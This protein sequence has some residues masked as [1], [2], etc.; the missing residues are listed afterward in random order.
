MKN[1]SYLITETFSVKGRVKQRKPIKKKWKGETIIVPK[2]RHK[3]RIWLTVR[4]HNLLNIL[5]RYH[6][7][8]GTVN[9]Q[10]KDENFEL[11]LNNVEA[12]TEIIP[13]NATDLSGLMGYVFEIKTDNFKRI[14]R[15]KQKPFIAIDNIENNCQIQKP[16]PII[17]RINAV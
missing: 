4:E 15:I 13:I 6:K 1:L 17:D 2:R 16:T 9:R 7:P 10:N 3:I 8:K 14:T 5:D 12:E 11:W